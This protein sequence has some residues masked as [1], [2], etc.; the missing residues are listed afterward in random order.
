MSFF[1]QDVYLPG[2]Q[3]TLS[4]LTERTEVVGTV[5]ELSDSGTQTSAFAV[6]EFGAD[7]RVIVPVNKVAS[8]MGTS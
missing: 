7:Q 6:I 2:V 3:E 4:A 5:I 1:V 8:L